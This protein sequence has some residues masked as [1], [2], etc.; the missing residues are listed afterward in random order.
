MVGSDSFKPWTVASTHDS[1]V[2]CLRTKACCKDHTHVQLKGSKTPKSAFPIA[3]CECII[4]TLFPDKF[5]NAV[6]C[7]PCSAVTQSPVYVPNE[8]DISESI[9]VFVHELIDKKVWKQGPNALEEA[10][11]EAQGLIEAGTWTYD[12]VIPCY[13][14][15]K[16][17]R[18]KG[19][20][21]AIGKLMT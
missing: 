4:A 5:H 15:E 18:A 2:R 8:V 11:R 1:L 14:L 9:P 7:M 6:P 3:M 20:K 19:N 17:A 10:K 21:I 13:L 12:K 16:E